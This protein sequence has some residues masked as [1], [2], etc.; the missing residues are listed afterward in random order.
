MRNRFLRL[1]QPRSE[2]QALAELAKKAGA[3]Q[4]AR[5]ADGTLAMSGRDGQLAEPIEYDEGDVDP[6]YARIAC[7][8][9]GHKY[10]RIDFKSA[11]HALSCDVDAA[12]A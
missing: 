10:Q 7:P 6:R 1:D 12:E 9:C 8:Q 4:V 11:A 5:M 3:A 2:R